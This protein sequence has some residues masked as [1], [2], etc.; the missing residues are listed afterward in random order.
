MKKMLYIGHNYHNKTKS[1]EFLIEL[2]K[3]KYI[4]EEADHTIYS[5][6]I[7]I[8]KNLKNKHYDVI[9][10]FQILPPRL[11]LKDTSFES[12]IFFPCMTAAQIVKIRSGKIIRTF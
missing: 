1:T 9:V 2:F 3:E 12:G 8:Q 11:I 6:D 7:S 10:L 4:V 5:N